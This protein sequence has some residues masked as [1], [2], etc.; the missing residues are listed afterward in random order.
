MSIPVA[1]MRPFVRL[2]FDFV[3]ADDFDPDPYFVSFDFKGMANGG[4]MAVVKLVDPD[5]TVFEDLTRLGFFHGARIQPLNFRFQIVA[6]ENG[7]FPESATKVQVATIVGFKSVVAD[8]PTNMIEIVGVD[9]VTYLLSMGTASGAAITGSIDEVVK[10]L[11]PGGVELDITKF[12]GSNKMNWYMMRQDPKSFILSLLD[13]ASTLTDSRSQ[14]LVGMDGYRLQI[15]D[16]ASLVSRQRGFYRRFSLDGEIDTIIEHH[17]VANSALSVYDGKLVTHGNSTLS[18]L[19]LDQAMDFNNNYTA[20]ADEQTSSKYVPAIDHTRGFS[21]PNSG[22]NAGPYQIGYTA[23]PAIPELFSGGEIG[24][25]Y[26]AYI[27]GRARSI[28]HGLTTAL[29]KMKLTVIGHGEFSDTLGLGADTIFI[30]MKRPSADPEESYM[31]VSGNWLVYGFHHRVTVGSWTTDLLCA[32]LDHDASGK[33][34]GV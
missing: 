31:W 16:Q 27:D 18:G 10:Q 4:Y 11:I 24:I 3:I 7:V 29:C 21:K 34:V 33:R 9:P 14:I 5:L 13:W 26:Q 32:R 2:K 15:K 17:V 12:K 30:Q 8:G 23:I 1:T 22:P 25:P 19:Y 6:D 28:Y 20:V